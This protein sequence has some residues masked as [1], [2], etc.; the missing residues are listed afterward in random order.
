MAIKD[1]DYFELFVKS[2]SVCCK[3][4]E[5]LESLVKG[6]ENTIEK[7][8]AIHEVEHEGD[9]LYHKIYG[10]LNRSFITPIERE[11]IL[12]IARYI[13]ETIDTIDE[14]AIMFNMLSVTNIRD[15]GKELIKLISK[16]CSAL[17]DATIEFKNFKKSKKLMP[18]LVEINHIEE[19]G[20]RLYQSSVKSLFSN[21]TNVMEVIKWKNIFDTLENVLD[22]CEN[23]ADV[24]ESVIVK[25]S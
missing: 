8:A 13:E 15:D 21:E 4:A 20:D 7:I 18:L 6:N 9:V 12:L 5:Q 24:M 11:D 2:A 19:E 16:S 1:V 25:N 14:V 17:L 23:V 10:H 3:A 22:A